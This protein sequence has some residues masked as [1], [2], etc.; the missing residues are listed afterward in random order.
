MIIDV[1]CNLNL[2]KEQLENRQEWE[3]RSSH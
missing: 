2:N 1:E 3:N